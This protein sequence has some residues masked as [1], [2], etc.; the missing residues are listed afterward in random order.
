ML[1]RVWREGKHANCWWERTLVNA[2][3]KTVKIPQKIKNKTVMWSTYFTSGYISKEY[4]NANS[5]RY[6]HSYI[7]YSIISSTH[8]MDYHSAIKKYEILS[9]ATWMYFEGITLGE[10]SQMEE[11]R[12]W[13]KGSVLWWWMSLDFHGDHFAM[14][15]N[16]GL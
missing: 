13:T 7:Y 2:L 11:D 3:W 10:V 8:T 15:A 14:H 4:K 5:K 6:M 16:I 1:K 9:F 12:Y